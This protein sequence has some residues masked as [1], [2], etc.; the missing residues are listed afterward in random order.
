VRRAAE[1][2]AQDGAAGVAAAKLSPGRLAR[3]AQRQERVAAALARRLAAEERRAEARAAADE[4]LA[5][6]EAYHAAEEEEQ[7]GRERGRAE[8]RLRL[9]YRH[10]PETLR[11]L[12]VEPEPEEESVAYPPLPGEA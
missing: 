3:R 11:A 9:A 8:R 6:W 10:A 12:G 1:E 4:G 2:E 7:R 5:A